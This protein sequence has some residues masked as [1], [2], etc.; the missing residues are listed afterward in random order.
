MLETIPGVSRDCAQVIIAETGADMSVFPDAKHLVS[1]SGCAPGMNESAGKKKPTTTRPGNTYL[2]GALG[3][4]ALAASRTK[5]T[6]L[7]ALYRRVASRRGPMKALVAVENSILT[8]IWHMLTTGQPYQELGPDYYTRRKPRQAID[9]AIQRI[10]DLG[11][12][13]TITPLIPAVAG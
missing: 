5:K 9:Q 4:A 1:W 8:A 6:Y 7:S 13:V 12:N 3:V 10:R 11:Y 2:K